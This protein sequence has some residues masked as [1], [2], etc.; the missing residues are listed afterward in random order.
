VFTGS[1]FSSQE[2]DGSNNGYGPVLVLGAG[3]RPYL[4]WRRHYHADACAAPV[5]E[6]D[7]GTYYGTKVGDAWQSERLTPTYGV[8]SLTVDVD[9]G[10]VH[11]LISDQGGLAYLSRLGSESWS[12]L[13]FDDVKPID[14]VIRHDPLTGALLVAYIRYERYGTNRVYVAQYP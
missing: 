1:G 8:A 13:A 2:I 9:A 10:R 7:D 3:D 11:L 6:P 5:D 4:L 14:A 12:T